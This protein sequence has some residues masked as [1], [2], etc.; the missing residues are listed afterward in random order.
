MAEVSTR[1]VNRMQEFR[2]D[3][4]KEFSRTNEFK[5]VMSSKGNNVIWVRDSVD[6][7]ST[8]FPFVSALR[9]LGVTGDT[10]L[11]GREEAL[12]NDSHRIW[13]E[14]Y[15][16]AIKVTEKT[17]AQSAIDLLEAGR[18]DLKDWV[19]ESIRYQ[20]IAAFMSVGYE[21]AVTSRSTYNHAWYNYGYPA[22]P[23][24]TPG[25][26]GYAGATQLNNW[27]AYNGPV[28]GVHNGK[29]LYGAA[30]SNYNA[31]FATAAAN[32]DTS[33]DKMTYSIVDLAKGMAQNDAL[34]PRIKP[35]TGN[36]DK[37]T[38]ETYMCFMH[39]TAFQHLRD[40]LMGSGG[41]YI[42]Q[43]AEAR[44]RDNPL[45]RAGDLWW[46]G[47]IC[48]ALP[49]IPV[50]LNIG[51]GGNTSVLP[52]FLCGKNAIG[53]GFGQTPKPVTD[54]EDYG[55]RTGAGIAMMCGAEKLLYTNTATSHKE[56]CF[57][58]IFTSAG[59]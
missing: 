40:S 41:G 7:E 24:T 25:S 19:Q 46:N 49:G 18:S 37:F 6:G 53:F 13:M 44:G 29:I 21:I 23:T 47:V 39:P 45:F 34:N 14:W 4:Q 57:V 35:Y 51:N 55:F 5:R 20:I 15:R 56:Q 12:N 58:T 16:N 36:G 3:F 10:A 11:E 22:S 43:Q 32:I 48:T 8:V 27:N 28:T 26:T 59:Y 1:E 54:L 9:G 31:T 33:A 50:L 17:K 30:T 2:D 42:L 52:S 38:E